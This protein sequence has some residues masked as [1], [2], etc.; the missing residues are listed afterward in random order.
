MRVQ[1]CWA[2][3]RNIVQRHTTR[4]GRCE[5]PVSGFSPKAHRLSN[6]C[7]KQEQRTRNRLTPRKDGDL[8][9][10]ITGETF[11]SKLSNLCLELERSL[12]ELLED[13][14]D[15][16]EESLNHP[17]PSVSAPANDIM[18]NDGLLNRARAALSN[19]AIARAQGLLK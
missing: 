3:I 5:D 7:G 18:K 12:I 9:N 10:C 13:Y 11:L 2:K 8:Y 19:A 15:G 16:C 14:L 1:K 4:V 6:C 17:D